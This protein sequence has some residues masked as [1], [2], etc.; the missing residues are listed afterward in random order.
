MNLLPVALHGNSHFPCA[1]RAKW[2]WY[3]MD[4]SAQVRRFG[5]DGGHVSGDWL[6]IFMSIPTS[7][8]MNPSH[9]HQHKYFTYCCKPLDTVAWTSAFNPPAFPSNAIYTYVRP[10][11]K[12]AISFFLCSFAIFPAIPIK[13]LDFGCCCRS[14]LC[15]Y[16]T[17]G[18]YCVLSS[19]VHF[20]WFRFR[21]RTFLFFTVTSVCGTEFKTSHRKPEATISELREIPPIRYF[22]SLSLS[23]RRG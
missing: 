16:F 20:F 12:A 9:K 3:E 8:P 4:A 14:G 19:S 22:S 5:G 17:S 1:T 21:M 6:E 11:R 10:Y 15:F 13:L 7:H 23:L 2:E 18:G